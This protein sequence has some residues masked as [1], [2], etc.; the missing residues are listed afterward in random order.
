RVSSPRP[1][2]LPDP[3]AWARCPVTRLP[4]GKASKPSITSEVLVVP[5]ISWPA[6]A[7]SD[8]K[9][10]SRRRWRVDPSGTVTVYRGLVPRSRPTS[11]GSSLVTNRETLAGAVRPADELAAQIAPARITRIAAAQPTFPRARPRRAT[12]AGNGA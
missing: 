3:A 1:D 4:A 11:P 2:T 9:G 12:G 6:S 10:V 7:V 5:V 8:D